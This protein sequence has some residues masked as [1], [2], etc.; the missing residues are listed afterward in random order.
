MPFQLLCGSKL[1]PDPDRQAT[2]LVFFCILAPNIIIGCK[3][4]LNNRDLLVLLVLSFTE[5]IF[6]F[7]QTSVLEPDRT[8]YWYRYLL[9]TGTGTT[10]STD[11]N[12]N[13]DLT[14][15]TQ[16]CSY[17][18]LLKIFLGKII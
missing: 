17:K 12:E 4:F 16:S 18:L 10:D 3:I 11:L 13:S 2:T 1:D 9:R 14:I 8:P 6:S 15:W 7:V 5:K